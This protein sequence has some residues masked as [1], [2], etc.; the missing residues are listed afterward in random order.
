M[1][2]C[3]GCEAEMQEAFE[4]QERGYDVGLD[5]SKTYEC[6]GLHC[7]VFALDKNGGFVVR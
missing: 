5:W 4:W 7:F 3:K 2:L 6:E 1:S